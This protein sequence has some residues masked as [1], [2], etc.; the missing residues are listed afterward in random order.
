MKKKLLIF[1]G[2][3]FIGVN[4]SK[5]AQVNGWD[6][7][8]A[9]SSHKPDIN[10][11]WIKVDITNQC[12]V[13]KTVEKVK[14]DAV[15]NL[16]AIA[17][18]D[19]AEQNKELAWKINVEG[20]KY[21]GKS[22][23]VNRIKYIF[24]STDAVFDGEK[25]MYFEEDVPQPINYYGKTKAEAEKNVLAICPSAVVV[26]ISTAIGYNLTGGKSFLG[27]LIKNLDH[28]K[29][30]LCPNYELRTPID[31]VTL[32]ECILELGE[33]EFSGI[34]HIGSTDSVSRY[35]LTKRAALIMGFDDKLV[36]ASISVEIDKQIAPR[37]KNGVISVTKAQSLL[38]TRL[39]NVNESIQKIVR[40]MNNTSA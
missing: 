28:G 11:N 22:C 30:I 40:E 2:S 13:N 15:V 34:L 16:A 14:P 10:V 33:S 1:G 27:Q 21:I 7:H 32:S 18:I 39:L 3:G 20:A 29:E 8:I 26:R 37:H 4:L 5:I 35:E 17:N 31:V 12:Q 6:V 9:S 38:K 24:L 23:A 19:V 25:D 36:R